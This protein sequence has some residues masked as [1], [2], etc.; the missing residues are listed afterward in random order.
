MV[1]SLSCNAG[2]AGLIPGRSGI[3]HAEKQLNLHAAT[4]ETRV[5][6]SLSCALQLLSA[7]GTTRKPEPQQKLS[8]NLMKT[9]HATTKT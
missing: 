5:L 7:C 2:D 3:P 6:W 8:H 9:P 1:K 4:P